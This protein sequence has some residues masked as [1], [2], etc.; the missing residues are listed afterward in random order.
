MKTSTK[1]AS[2]A[3]FTLVEL[4]IASSLAAVL[5]TAVMSTYVYVGRSLARLASYQ[6]LEA[7]SR[8]ALAYL[9]K[10]FAQAQ[11]IKNGTSPTGTT[12]TLVLP[13]GEVVYSY[14]STAKSLRRQ[15]TF[16]AI[17]DLSFFQNDTSQCPSLTFRYFTTSDGAPTSQLSPTSNVPYSI[18][19]VQVGYI[20]ESPNTW[21]TLTRTRYE[22]SSARFLFRNRGMPDGT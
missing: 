10:D 15:A 4:L 11:G 2:R 16:G 9:T 21:S 18:K 1:R 12:L 13:S 6:A 3:G 14:D 7:E 8:K 19:Q 17:R 20:V 22:A 5:M